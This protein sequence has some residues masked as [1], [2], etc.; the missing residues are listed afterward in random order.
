VAREGG[1]VRVTDLRENDASGGFRKEVFRAV[2]DDQE[3]L[4]DLVHLLLDSH[5]PPTL[6]PDLCDAVGIGDFQPSPALPRDPDFRPRVLTAYEHRCAVC[7]WDLRLGD[8]LIGVEAAHIQWHQARGPALVQN[9]LALCSLHHKLFDRGVFSLS[10]G[11]AVTVSE[12]AHG[13]S[14]LEEALL[15]FH[16]A[17]IRDPVNPEYR[18]WEAYLDWHRREVFQGPG[19]V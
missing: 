10:E 17:P 12:R 9:G 6:H 14:G 15:R 4:D 1:D 19:R 2:T 3:L 16:R 11:L 8:V 18:P 5:F 13:S 7:G